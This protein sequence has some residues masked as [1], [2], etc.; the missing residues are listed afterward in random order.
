MA[1]GGKKVL[2]IIIAA[3]LLALGALSTTG[4]FVVNPI[5]TVPEGETIWYYRRGTGLPFVSSADSLT[6]KAGKTVSSEERSAMNARVAGIIGK[7]VISKL[8]YSKQMYLFS[9]GNKDFSAI[10]APQKAAPAAPA[11]AT[12]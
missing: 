5:P 10:G 4:F 1:Q 11:P 8:G 2:F 3:I 6:V 9:T 7:K 12:P